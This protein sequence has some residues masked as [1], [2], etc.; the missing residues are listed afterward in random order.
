MY[1]RSTT[2]QGDPATLDEAIAFVGKKEFPAITGIPGCVGLSMLADR[3]TGRV[4]V[5]SAWADEETMK[6]S[7]E[8]VR[9]M[10][11]RLM[12]MLKAED[13]LIQPWDI[14]VLHRD[15]PSPDGA[16]AAVTWSRIAPD[17]MDTLLNAYRGSMLA[18]LQTLPGFCSLSLVVDRKQGRTVSVTSFESRDALERTR[19][20]ARS[21]REEFAHAVGARIVDIA[22]MD[23]AV[24]HLHVPSTD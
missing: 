9:P 18:R 4:I 6:S 13:S 21:M 23:V 19:K 1:A 11:D 7:A 5:S 20:E 22:E 10:Q 17:R 8:M 16:R 24:A 2:A 14:A 3:D 15:R 12:R